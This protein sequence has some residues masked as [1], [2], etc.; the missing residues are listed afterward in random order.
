MNFLKKAS[1][2]ALGL[3]FLVPLGIALAAPSSVDRLV[4][5]IEPLIKTDYIKASYFT[6]TTTTATSTLQKTN[7]AGAVE[8]GG[9]YFTNLLTFLTSVCSTITGG[10]GLCDGTDNT[11]G[12]GGLATST[13]IADTEVIYGTSANDVGSEAAFTYDDATN[14]LTVPN[15]STTALSSGYASSTNTVAGILNVSTSLT[16]GGDT[17]LDFVGDGLELSAGTLIFDC[18]DVAST[19]ITCVGEDITASLGTSVDLAS[20]EVTGTLPV[21]N[22]GTGTT[23]TASGYA[24]YWGSAGLRGAPTSTPAIGS[25]LSYSGTL[26]SFINGTS[27]T[28]GINN[29]VLTV[30]MLA[31]ADFGDFTC[32]GSACTNDANSIAL[33][34]DTTGNYVETV[35]GTTNQIAVS[36]SGAEDADVTISIPADFRVSS[37]TLSGNTLLVNAT[38]TN[39]AVT[40]YVDLM[41]SKFT[42]FL[43]YLTSVCTTITGGAGLCDGT[44]NTG[45]GG[46]LATSTDI[47]DTQVIWGTSASDVGSEA[48]FT[49]D[50]S[51]NLLTVDSIRG[52]AS[53]T[54]G[55]GTA[56]GGLTVS[57]HATTTLGALF[58]RTNG[59][60]Q[61]HDNGW[62]SVNTSE[63]STG[64]F[65]FAPL[66]VSTAQRPLLDLND[67]FDYALA[68]RYD[69]ASNGE[70]TGL[71]FT[72]TNTA[73]NCGASI[74]HVRTGGNSQGDLRFYTKSSAVS[75]DDPVERLRITENGLVG[76][77][78]SSPYAALS[79]VGE[80]V[81]SHFTATTTSTSTMP[82]LVVNSAIE[83][84]GTFADSLSD[85]CV[86]ITGGA[87]LCDGTDATGAGGTGLATSTPIADTQ[88][89]YGTSA[90]DVGA[91]AAFTYDD[92]TDRMT[93]INASTTALSS[94]YASSTSMVAGILSVSTSLTLGGDTILDFVGDGLELSAGTLIFDCSDVASTGITCVGEDITASLGTAIDTSEITDGTIIEPDLDADD[95][96][97]DGEVLTYDTTGTNFVWETILALVNTI[98][99]AVDWGGISSF[100]IP[101]GTGMTFSQTG[102]IYYD[103]TDKQIQVA[104][105]TA[106]T[107]AA[108]PTVVPMGSFLISS[109]TPPFF[110]GFVTS[111][112]IPFKIHRDGYVVKEIFCDIDGGTSIVINFDNGSGNTETITCDTDGASDTDI[113]AN[114]TVTAGLMTTAIETG[115]V[116]GSPDYLRVT[117]FGT[118]SAE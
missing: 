55:D 74:L 21:A 94:G 64:V 47:A 11:G 89:I 109:T 24:A 65:P 50:D 10:A 117:V 3:L 18:S 26:G 63:A 83:L 51:T 76:I 42:N 35:S 102:Q 45:G 90:A 61:I 101:N 46:G 100:E 81:A 8:I 43:T 36:G 9:S 99:G 75:G 16:M 91:E 108:I 12:G 85:L 13:P 22:G 79:V 68:L 87:D 88:I 27:G 52:N 73:S 80:T 4:D 1:I 57:G 66:G 29:G 92:A 95:S 5:H 28:F 86:A 67:T 103:T 112:A 44:D 49:Y 2:A 38:T 59:Y 53:S 114:N 71:C 30:G 96:P 107:P 14:R 54:I 58:D 17:I 15:A 32:N 62:T 78:T 19:G 40:G 41:G 98:T 48:A 6:A 111:T 110:N 84:L 31:S 7:I 105:T 77:S 69:A 39:L 113:A 106:N 25:V 23:T 116:T 118:Y 97:N 104:T 72:V 56:G 93:V 70:A 34:T 60:V 37:T 33:T 115:T 82:R 20:A